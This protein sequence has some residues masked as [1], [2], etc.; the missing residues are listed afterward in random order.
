MGEVGRSREQWRQAVTQLRRAA[1]QL[2][3]LRLGNLSL[4]QRLGCRRVMQLLEL[5]GG[6]KARQLLSALRKRLSI[7]F[8]IG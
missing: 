2:L 4:L 7:L 3:D 6:A 1:P 5:L 8:G